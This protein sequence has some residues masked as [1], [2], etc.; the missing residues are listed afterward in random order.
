MRN[1]SQHRY[2]IKY[3]PGMSRRIKQ[4]ELRLFFVK[5]FIFI[6]FVTVL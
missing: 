2:R 3:K 6:S 4:K 1:A 5:T